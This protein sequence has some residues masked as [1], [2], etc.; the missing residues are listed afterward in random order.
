[1]V[2][3]PAVSNPASPAIGFVFLV[4]WQLLAPTTAVA[5]QDRAAG[6]VDARLAV[7]AGNRNPHAKVENDRGPLNPSQVMPA[8]SIV[9]KK[10]AAQT[11]DFAN[12]LQEQ[13]DP[14]SPNYHAWLTPDQYADRFGLSPSDLAKVTAWIESGGFRVE[15]VSRS[16]T[17]VMFTGTADQV[18]SALHTEIRRYEVN[19]KLH[20]ANATDP[21]IPAALQ[22]LVLMVRGLDDF[23]LE[24]PI[25]LK[26]LIPNVTP[27]PN[28][29]SGG[30]HYLVPSDV[31]TIYDINPLYQ[32]GFTG[33]GQKIAVVGQTDVVMSDIE[34]FRTRFSLPANDPQVVL[35]PGSADPRIS[36]NDQIEASLDLEYAG[37]IAPNATVLFVNSTDVV[38]SAAY[39]IDQDLAPVISM[40][41]GGCESESSSSPASA[42]AYFQ[43]L[44]QQANSSGITWLAASGDTGA[45]GCD[46]G[47]GVQ[48]ASH[49][50]EVDLPAS[51]P[52]VTAVG[53]TEF[54]EGGGTYWS[55]TNNANDGSAL[56]YIPEKAW[57]DTVV[58]V[59]A[60]DGLAAS[61]G[62][63]SILFSKPAWQA[64]TG[65]PNDSARDVPDISFSAA[66]EHDPY[67]IYENGEYWAVG[68]TSAPTPVFSGILAVLNQYL[69][70]NHVLSKPGLGNINTTLYRLAQ[71]T[72]GVFHDI[73]VG[74]NIVPCTAGS[75]NC[76]NGQMGYSAGAGYD[77]ATGL[78]SLDINSLATHWSTSLAVATTTTVSA[79]PTSIASSS[80]TV[81]TATVSA[82]SGTTSP[83]GSVS[84]A[85]GQTALGSGILSGSGGSATANLTVQG[86]LLSSGSNVISASYG[87][88]ATSL[89]SSGSVTVNVAGCSYA[90][91]SSTA[92]VGFAGATATVGVVADG[93]CSWAASSNA[94]WLT[95]TSGTS[96]TGDGT[97][98]YSFTANPGTS[99]RIGTLTIAGQ[100]FTV[101]QAGG[102]SPLAFFTLTPCRIADTRANSGF[103]GSFGSPSL[104]AGTARSFPI[105]SS[106]CN[107]PATAQA[108]SFN[109]TVV[110]QGTLN[111][112]TV[113]PTGQTIPTVSTLNSYHGQTLANAAIVPAGTN[114][115]I[116]VFATNATDVIIDI[117]GYF[118][119]PTAPQ[120]LAFYP[121]TPCRVVDTRAV[122]GSG[123]SGAFGPPQMPAGSTRSFPI[124]SS[125][126]DLPLSAEAYSFN[127]TVVPPSLLEYLSTWPVGQTMP[128]VSTLN[129]SSGAVVANAALVPAGTNGAVDVFVPNATNLIIDTNGYFAPPGSTGAL[130]F[131]PLTPCRVADTRAV[132]GG[133]MTGAFGPPQMT[134]GSTRSFP[135]LS[136]SCGIP[137]TAQA[138]SLNLT[139]VPP[140]PL[141]YITTWPTG[142]AMPLVSTLNDASGAVVANAAIVPAGSNGA[143]SVFAYSAT[144]LIIDINGYFAP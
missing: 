42:G 39:A 96:G 74:N 94:S 70:S 140:G 20:Y 36:S 98:G 10:S 58:S 108:Y 24:A 11:A 90:L 72:T 13:Q 63:A 25:P 136:S 107:V 114:G 32:H 26:A 66:N 12:L 124:P 119:P 37:A 51:V 7:L 30:T 17:W 138:Y 139:V 34:A 112:L 8:M 93:G 31:G 78:G 86:I 5:Q 127:M 21:S 120:A 91:A 81:L 137:A 129:D 15:Y 106:S 45:A 141:N 115:A 125:S 19:G 110:P 76:S 9:F 46:I 85:I 73:T 123:L 40:S 60:G 82:N 95:I 92:S 68:G 143:I 99:A 16:R 116:S 43:S 79:N 80:S 48:A 54:T 41:Y 113:W 122:G 65:V 97:V 27:H 14:T 64:G 131:Y 87:G 55:A 18:Q 132:G 35:V 144:D 130:N 75:P 62:G 49:G 59:G 67:L 117:N 101:T 88:N 56:S 135:V 61:G 22:P 38:T 104:A 134:A 6:T 2:I 105:P 118:A 71:T 142:L 103:T 89:A 109:I 52:E 100:T 28:F 69:V 128:V 83:T 121:V 33:S 57:N 23:R 50:L 44:A 102:P 126:C 77:Q 133:G 4:A 3:R 84:F 53:G 47:A 29:T 111:Y 1:M